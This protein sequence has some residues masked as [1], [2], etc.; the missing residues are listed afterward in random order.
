MRWCGRFGLDHIRTG[1]AGMT[2]SSTPV[3]ANAWAA[4]TGEISPEQAFRNASGQRSP[5]A[6]QPANATVTRRAGDAANLAGTAGNP[7]GVVLGR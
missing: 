2:A 3:M 5:A 6:M 4:S 7:T 1:E